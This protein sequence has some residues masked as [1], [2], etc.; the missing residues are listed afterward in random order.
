MR[1][2]RARAPE[3]LEVFLKGKHSRSYTVVG[4]GSW[5]RQVVDSTTVVNPSSLYK[6]TYAMLSYAGQGSGLAK[7]RMT[8]DILRI[9]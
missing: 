2:G 3:S 5:F 8:A 7:D 4:L 9:S 6:G 1:A